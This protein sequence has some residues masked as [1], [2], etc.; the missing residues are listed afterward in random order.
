[1]IGA[2]GAGVVAVFGMFAAV[3]LAIAAN[4]WLLG[5]ETQGRTLDEISKPSPATIQS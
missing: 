1:M 4:V 2:D 3:L 5:E